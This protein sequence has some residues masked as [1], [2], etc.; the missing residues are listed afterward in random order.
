M[1]LMMITVLTSSI[2]TKFAM[3]SLYKLLCYLTLTPLFLGRHVCQCLH[4]DMGNKFIKIDFL[5]HLLGWF[6]VHIALVNR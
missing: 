2:S 6:D 3:T 5:F 4:V 1:M